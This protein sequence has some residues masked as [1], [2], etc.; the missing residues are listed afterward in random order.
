MIARFLHETVKIH[1][2]KGLQVPAGW[3]ILPC[4]TRLAI[5]AANEN[6][7]S[8]GCWSRALPAL[9]DAGHEV[10]ALWAVEDAGKGHENANAR[11]IAAFG[12]WNFIKFGLFGT[13]V[14]LCQLMGRRPM[15]LRALAQKHGVKY[16]ET[17]DPNDAAIADWMEK[18]GVDIAL[19]QVPQIIKPPLL[20]KAQ[21]INHHAGLL[22]ANRG[23]YPYFWA[24]LNGSPQGVS[25]HLVNEKIDAGP[26]LYQEMEMEP[27]ELAS[28]TV[29]E[30]GALRE[31]PARVLDALSNLKRKM[32]QPPPGVSESY[33]SFPAREDYKAFRK[34]R[35]HIIKLRDV[36]AQAARLVF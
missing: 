23:I 36:M 3:P 16:L 35:G 1:N 31:Y 32:I 21:L 18:E 6:I 22:P 26:L 33:N 5:I 8:L 28:M 29:F 14:R 17:P 34:Q 30:V 10:A 11:Y 24:V 13:M 9:K 7:W 19:I 25:L 15:S 2:L 4:M 20:E 27:Q 12:R